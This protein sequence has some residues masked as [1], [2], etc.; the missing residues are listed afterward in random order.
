MADNVNIK[1][2][3][4]VEIETSSMCNR[5]CPACIRNSHPNRQIV[6][7]WFERHFMPM[8]TI[9]KILDQCADLGYNGRVC[10]SHYNEPLM[11]HRILQIAEMAKS[12]NRFF[13]HLCT[14]GDF[15][16]EQ[17]LTNLDKATTRTKHIKTHF[18]TGIA[19]RIEAVK[20]KRCVQ[21]RLI[22]NHKGEY[23]L[24][25]EDMVG[26]FDLGKFPDIN[27]KDYWFGK[28]HTEIINNFRKAGGRLKYSYCSQCPR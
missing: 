6:K 7:S 26:N 2:F 13:V 9:K 12:Y 10:L 1:L 24:C 21:K 28:K 20:N 27:I 16:V 14:N 22:I 8:E 3:K 15:P 17:L 25:C 23:L 5:F 11:D 4:R 18:A 19:K